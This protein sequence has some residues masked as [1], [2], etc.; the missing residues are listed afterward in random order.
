ML[1]VSIRKRELFYTTVP[2]CVNRSVQPDNLEKK[3]KKENG[4]NVSVTKTDEQNVI[5]RKRVI[6]DSM[7]PQSVIVGHK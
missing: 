3:K 1:H 2:N 7:L 4:I 6:F 5:S